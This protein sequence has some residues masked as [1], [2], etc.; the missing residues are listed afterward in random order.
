M[1]V[2][3]GRIS[4]WE[5]RSAVCRSS[6]LW[7]HV[8]DAFN[9]P[10]YVEGAPAVAWTDV[11]TILPL[12]TKSRDTWATPSSSVKWAE[13]HLPC[14][15]TGKI[16]VAGCEALGLIPGHGEWKLL[17]LSLLYAN[18]QWRWWRRSIRGMQV[19]LQES[20]LIIRVVKITR[21]EGRRRRWSPEAGGG[22]NGELLFDGYGVSVL[23]DEKHSGAG[24]WGW[25]TYL[26]TAH[27]KMIK[28]IDLCYACFTT[29]RKKLKQTNKKASCLTLWYSTLDKNTG[30]FLK[31]PTTVSHK[32]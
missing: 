22:R 29:I 23:E 10:L 21:T 9:E 6:S 3:L 28:M 11:S 15:G 27:L 18:T 12:P 26:W 20:Y 13:C 5:T 32:K 19:H 8:R 4:F 1:R 16:R 14:R 31:E 17:S 2:K 25:L 24:W 30:E 7:G